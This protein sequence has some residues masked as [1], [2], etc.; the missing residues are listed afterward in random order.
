MQNT[1]QVPGSPPERNLGGAR[2]V[3]VRGCPNCEGVVGEEGEIFFG[4]RATRDADIG[5]IIGG[6]CY[7]AVRFPP[8][9]CQERIV[10]NMEARQTPCP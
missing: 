7:M 8:N 9:K 6:R 5:A 2:T 10:I 3:G 1:V 4:S